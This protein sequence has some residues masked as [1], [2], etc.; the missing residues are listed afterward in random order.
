MRRRRFVTLTLTI[1]LV[2]GTT[3]VLR[4]VLS[5]PGESQS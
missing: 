1:A 3:W 4:A 2:L 5:P